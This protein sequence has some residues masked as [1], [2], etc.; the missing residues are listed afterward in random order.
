MLSAVTAQRALWLKPWTAYLSSKTNWCRIPFNGIKLFRSKLEP[1]ISK[2]TSGKSGSLPED[3]RSRRLTY[4]F[5]DSRS[6]RPGK[7]YHKPWKGTRLSLIRINRSITTN[8]SEPKKLFWHP[9]CPLHF[10]K[11]TFSYPLLYISGCRVSE[12][13]IT[14]TTSFCSPSEEPKCFYINSR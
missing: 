2:V 11:Q 9:N 13:F 4:P 3:R 1:A 6:Y 8:P 7:E 12:C 10:Y 5:K 14:W